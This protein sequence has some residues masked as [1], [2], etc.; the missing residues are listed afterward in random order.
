[1]CV[2]PYCESSAKVD[3]RCISTEVYWLKVEDLGIYIA[4]LTYKNRTAL[5]G[6]RHAGK[7]GE[8][9]SARTMS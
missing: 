6:G 3:R 8:R 1:M 2:L 7:N 9:S 4:T 5:Q